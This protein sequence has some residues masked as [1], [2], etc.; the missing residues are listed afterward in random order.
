MRTRTSRNINNL[1]R[2]RTG[3]K[4]AERGKRVLTFSLTTF[5]SVGLSPLFVL[6]RLLCDAKPR[7]PSISFAVLPAPPRCWSGIRGTLPVRGG[8]VCGGLRQAR[9]SL[10]RVTWLVSISGV[11]SGRQPALG[12]MASGVLVAE[13]DSK[14]N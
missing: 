13:G 6:L 1:V 7:P 14:S 3:S 12:F 5:V 4:R 11:A 9:S 2:V 10:L 8:T